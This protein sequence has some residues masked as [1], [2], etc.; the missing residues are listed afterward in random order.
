MKKHIIILAIICLT[1]SHASLAQNSL[2]SLNYAVTVPL[3]NTNDYIDQMSGR[4]FVLEYQKFVNERWAFGGE[5]GHTT[6]YKKEANKVYTE[7]TAS[8]SGV[9]Y[10]YQYNWPIM[11]TANYYVMTGEALRPYF[12]LGMGTVAHD[13][14]IDMGIFTSQETHWQFAL[15]PEFGLYYQASEGVGFRFGAKYYQSFESGSLAGQSN[16]GLNFGIV[17]SN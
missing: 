17:F 3:G 12:G 5:I 6:L 10:R 15:R 13:R 4:G 1:V 14:Q 16:L 8:L 11:V 2:F 7:G 9:Q